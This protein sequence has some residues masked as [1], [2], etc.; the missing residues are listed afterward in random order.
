MRMGIEAARSVCKVLEVSISLED[1]LSQ[2][3]FGVFELGSRFRGIRWKIAEYR[4]GS[5]ELAS[6][7]SQ[8]VAICL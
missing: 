6:L 4:K 8:P 5:F 1:Q 7:R 3:R 2:F